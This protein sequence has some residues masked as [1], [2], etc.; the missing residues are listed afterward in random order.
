MEWIVNFDMPPQPPCGLALGGFDGLHRGHMAVIQATLEGPD[1]PAVFTFSAPPSGEA[2]VLTAADKKKL[3]AAAGVE[4]V[5]SAEFSALK[6]MEAASFV[7]T[8]LF[9]KINARR[10]C[11]GED[12][13]FGRGAAGDVGLLRELCQKHGV[14]LTVLPP[15][16][17]D[18]EKISSSRIRRAVERGDIPT[19]NRLLGRPFGFQLEV[20][21]GNHIGTGLGTPTINQ[22]L[23]ENFVRPRFGVYAAWCLVEGHPHFGVCNIGV[24]PTVGSDRVLAET[25]MPEFSGDLYGERV[26]VEL[27]E[28]LRPERKFDSLEEL[29]AA[30]QA[31]GEQA[32]ALTVGAE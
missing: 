32:R 17:E 18:G 2:M 9:E 27:V 11:C 29:K 5:Y 20:I 12:F 10:L 13:R 28:F 4:R 15:V 8:L 1:Q 24:K 7:E 16:S 14:G 26:R 31:N 30:I 6:T 19:A 25:W 23:P 3:L 21:H 22:A